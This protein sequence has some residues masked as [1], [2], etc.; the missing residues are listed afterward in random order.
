MRSSFSR[1]WYWGIPSSKT[2]VLTSRQQRQG[3]RHRSSSPSN[4]TATTV[5]EHAIPN[6]SSAGITW[7]QN[8]KRR[9]CPTTET[10]LQQVSLLFITTWKEECVWA[11][12][13]WT[14]ST[15]DREETVFRAFCFN[16]ASCSVRFRLYFTCWRLHIGSVRFRYLVQ[17][18]TKYL[19]KAVSL[20]DAVLMVLAKL[21]LTLLNR[22][23]AFRFNVS[24]GT[25][26]N[27]MVKFIPLLAETFL[28]F[29][30]ARPEIASTM[31]TLVHRYYPRCR[32][33]IDCS[34]CRIPQPLAFT[35]HSQMY[36]HYK[37]HVTL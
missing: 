22:D 10:A 32:V 35:A 14:S 15:L 4:T 37:C 34:E 27:I 21:L 17:E 29:I 6:N 36:W 24:K 1:S 12:L 13:S 3:R 28:K 7:K 23:L 19:A 25:V 26:A 30:T 33:I 18:G 31:P 16:F 8:G 5:S 2:N 11:G 9:Y 20:W